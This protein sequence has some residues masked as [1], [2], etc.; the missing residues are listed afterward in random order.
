MDSQTGRPTE[1]M[2]WLRQH[3]MH[4]LGLKVL[5]LA[6]AVLLWAAVAREQ[7]AEVMLNVPIEFHNPPENLEISSETIPAVQVRLRG[8]VGRVRELSPSEVHV[9]VNLDGVEPGE[10]TY[11][12]GP[13]RVRVPDRVEVVQVIPGQFRISLD[14]RASRQVEV[15]PRVTGSFASGYGIRRVLPEPQ[16]VTITGPARH[17][18]EV[19]AAITDPIDATGVVGRAT[20]TT[21]A[22]VTDPMV[23]L[24]NPTPIR[25]TVITEKAR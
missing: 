22:Y 15:H 9:I 1:E 20:F 14:Q 13:S 16:M 19:D 3:V 6:A 24:A 4:N 5:S 21:H 2:S 8:T 25:V 23:R 18:Q 11:D 12:L 17:V 7:V 10:R